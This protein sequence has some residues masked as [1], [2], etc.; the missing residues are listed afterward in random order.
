VRSTFSQDAVQ[1]F[2]VISD[3]Y[4][5]EFGKAASGLVNIVTRG[6]GN[7]FNGNLFFFL[8][9]DDLSARDVFAP[10]KPEYKQ[11]QFGAAVSGPIKKDR[12]FFFTSFERLSIHQNNFITISDASVQ[13][14][15]RVGYQLRNGPVPFGVG[16]S[17]VLGRFDGR[18]NPSDTFWVR[19]NYAGTYNGA[20]E[21]F[22]GLIAEGN[23]GIQRLDDTT[24]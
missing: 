23:G 12:A 20:F 3:N 2:Q 16:N 22:G 18:I 11:Y 13:A 8:R 5:A 14:A 10:V 19:I 6:G 9:N 21:P 7:E 24:I 4:S 15:N 17:A 1:E